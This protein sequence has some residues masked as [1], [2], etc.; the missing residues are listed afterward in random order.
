MTT[1][2]SDPLRAAL[3]Y[4]LAAAHEAAA[5]AASNVTRADLSEA[6][7]RVAARFEAELRQPL[8]DCG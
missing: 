2:N 5:A 4:A 8:G 1:P 3:L 6:L 7:R